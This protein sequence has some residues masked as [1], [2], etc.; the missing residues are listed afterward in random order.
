MATLHTIA[1]EIHERNKTVLPERSRNSYSAHL[2]ADLLVPA[3]GF[4]RSEL[5]SENLTREDLSDNELAL[6]EDKTPFALVRIDGFGDPS[7]Y[8]ETLQEEYQTELDFVSENGNKLSFHSTILYSTEG[9]GNEV[10][11][12]D[13]FING[14]RSDF[15]MTCDAEQVLHEFVTREFAN[16]WQYDASRPELT[17]DQI[18]QIAAVLGI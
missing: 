16:T 8:P 13:V 14:E 7:D 4:F 9:D 5:A 17:Q 2:M 11:D 3:R 18:D 6:F 1:A 15:F 12:V 10:Q